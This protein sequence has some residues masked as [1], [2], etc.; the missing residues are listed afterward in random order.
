MTSGVLSSERSGAAAR[1]WL[2]I[3]D[4]VERPVRAAVEHG[5]LRPL[6]THPI[7]HLIM[8]NVRGVLM[9]EVDAACDPSGT[10]KPPP[11]GSPAEAAEFITTVLFD[12]LLPRD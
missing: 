8:G 4:A 10:F 1:H 3:M 11:F 2:S 9:A 7:A 12:G 5:A 6:P